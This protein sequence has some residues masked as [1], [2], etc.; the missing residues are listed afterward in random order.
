DRRTRAGGCPLVHP[1]RSGDGARNGSRKLELRPAAAAGGSFPPDE[2]VVGERGM[3]RSPQTPRVTVDI[4][5]D[6]MC[7]WCAIG[8]AQFTKAVAEL[9]GAVEIETRWMP[10]E[11]NPDLPPEGKPQAEHIAEVYQRSDEEIAEMQQAMEARAEARSEE[12]TSE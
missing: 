3:S 5:S 12:H 10:F 6:I 11:L 7:P 2:V 1:L 9:E 8:Y 4:W